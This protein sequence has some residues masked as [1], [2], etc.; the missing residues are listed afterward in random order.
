VTL[1][2]I[3]LDLDDTLYDS[4]GLLLPP[5]DRRAVAA[6]RAAGLPL[7]EDEALARLSALRSEGE[8]APLGRLAR[9]AGA[10]ER[11]ALAGDAAWFRYDP[12][13]MTLDAAVDSALDE[14]RRVAPLALVTAG[15][16]GT[17]R[18]KAERLGLFARFVDLRFLDHR[19]RGAKTAA[20]ALIL[21][22]R[23]WRAARTVVCGDR[24]D[25]DVRAGNAN[26]CLTVLVRRPGGE[27]AAVAPSS[28]DDVPWRI[29]RSVVD[30]PAL[31]S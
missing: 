19:D 5:A 31:L 1:D 29:L 27:F 21:A 6:M 10:D 20:L 22:E 30:L 3:V 9:E 26:G 16:P 4:T 23:G 13:P 18:R 12:P 2:G 7:S 25:G 8:V 24:A 14:L 28:P 11:C 15:D 17:Q